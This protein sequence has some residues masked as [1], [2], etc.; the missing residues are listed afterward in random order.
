MSR[1]RTRQEFSRYN[2]ARPSSQATSQASPRKRRSNKDG[3]TLRKRTWHDGRP[4]RQRSSRKPWVDFGDGEVMRSFPKGMDEVTARAKAADAGTI[5]DR[6]ETR[7][8]CR[9]G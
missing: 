4:A 8:G 1:R 3:R 5:H 2:D 7:I 6:V 9:A